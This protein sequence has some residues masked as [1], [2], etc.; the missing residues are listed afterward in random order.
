MS[1]EIFDTLAAVYAVGALDGG[2]RARFEAHLAEG[3]P[4]CAAVLMRRVAPPVS[5][6]PRGSPV[7]RRLRWLAAT[8][9]AV[10]AGAAFTGAF[11]AAR[12]EARLGE[13]ARELAAIHEVTELLRDPATRL[14]TLRGLGPAPRGVAHVVWNDRTG[15][16][17]FV[18]NLEPAPPGKAYE[19]WTIGEGAPRP[20]ALVPVHASGTG[21]RRVEPVPGGEPVKVFAITI[22]PAGGVPAPTGPMILASE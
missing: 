15:G 3:C 12:Y 4:E 11:V 13:T 18:A 21:S 16:R 2:D 19:L 17:I 20:A 22:E 14:V 7:R 10:I 6:A 9:A 1:H 5:S 8:A